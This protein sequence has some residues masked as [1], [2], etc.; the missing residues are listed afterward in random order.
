MSKQKQ[1]IPTPLRERAS[2]P[3][4]NGLQSPGKKKKDISIINQM[5]KRTPPKDLQREE[6]QAF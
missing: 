3:G 6:T 4:K 2:I 5:Q 1:E